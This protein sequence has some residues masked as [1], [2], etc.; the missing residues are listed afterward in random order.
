V[1][2]TF[3]A[4][5]TN[6]GPSNAANLVLAITLS[7]DFRYAG[8]VASAGAVCTT[9]QVGNSGVISCTWAGATAVNGVRTLDVTA[10]S[11]NNNQNT[12]SVATSSGTPDPVQPNNAA[13]VSVAVGYLIEEIPTLGRNALLMLGLMLAL[14]GF[15][16][17]RRNS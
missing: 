8:H 6:L 1:P 14:A 2:V 5:S 11:N 7:P 12:V 4:T 17:V 15:V 16:A 3:S 13:T 10:F 9:P